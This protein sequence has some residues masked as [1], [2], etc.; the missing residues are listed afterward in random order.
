MAIVSFDLTAFLARYPEFSA[1]SPA[2]LAAY[3]NEAGL[4]LSNKD[5]SP[6]QD[7]ARRGQLLNMLTAH[8][9]KINGALS[10]DHLPAPVGRVSSGSEGSVSASFDYSLTPGT[11]AWFTQ[12]QY[13]A[14]FWQATVNLRTF[15]YFPC[16]AR[17]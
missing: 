10:S 8:V 7:V 15:R 5:D 16:P 11:H 4:Y 2:A 6:V 1:V 17:Y 9:G 14:A 12:T 13:G 3:F